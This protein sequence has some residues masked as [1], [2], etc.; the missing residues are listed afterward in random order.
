MGEKTKGLVQ[1]ARLNQQKQ[2]SPHCGFN[3]EGGVFWI[4]RH[5]SRFQ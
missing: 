5:Q 2:A 1:S 3:K 4:I